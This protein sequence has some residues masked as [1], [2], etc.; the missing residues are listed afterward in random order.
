VAA[1]RWLLAVIMG[2]GIQN[3]EKIEESRVLCARRSVVVMA[4]CCKKMYLHFAG[5]FISKMRI[6]PDNKNIKGEYQ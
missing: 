2:G 5:A 3:V 6:I 4:L 1:G